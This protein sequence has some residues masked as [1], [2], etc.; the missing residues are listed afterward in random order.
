MIRNLLGLMTIAM[1]VSAASCKEARLIGDYDS[2]PSFSPDAG[3]ESDAGATLDSNDTFTS[4]CPSSECP[5]DRTTCLSSRFPCDV[6]LR[7]DRGNCGACGRACLTGGG[8]ELYDCIDGNCVMACTQGF[9]CDGIPDN[10]CE[11]NEAP[12]DDHCG[13][14]GIK[15][16]DPDAPCVVRARAPSL[17]LGCGCRA[18]EMRCPN[19]ALD[20]LNVSDNDNNCGGC[21]V[22]C[23]PNRHDDAGVP[24]DS[25]YFGCTA[26]ECGQLKCKPTTGNCDGDLGNGCESSLLDAENCGFCGN[27][28]APGQACRLDVT[29]APMCACPE[30]E[31][32]CPSGLCAPGDPNCRGEC[33]NL[34]AHADHCG[35]CGMTCAGGS[36]WQTIGICNYGSCIRQCKEGWADCNGDATDGCETQTESDPKNCG[37]CGKVCDAVDGQACVGGRCVVKTCEPDAGD[38]GEEVPR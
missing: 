1:F 14:C 19:G 16:T 33:V 2:V 11:I 31:T 36:L 26:G 21:G 5:A 10:G 29:G 7:T 30:G 32:F 24:H 9:D 17:V 37:A 4:Y 12:N 25:M 23:D 38:S 6:D 27:A 15:C 13:G 22:V 34:R 20:C 28:C 18:G 35:A 8:G 3:A